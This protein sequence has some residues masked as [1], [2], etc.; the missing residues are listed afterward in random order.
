MGRH[1][2][3]D[4]LVLYYYGDAP[5]AHAVERHLQT[6]E[7][8]TATL[9]DIAATLDAIS[10]AD[11]PARD[12][13]YGLEV[14]QR[15]RHELPA[16]ESSG[17]TAW[18]SQRAALVAAAV[19]VVAAFAGGR[20]LRDGGAGRAQR[21]SIASNAPARLDR[22]DQPDLTARARF[23]AIGD[24][25][26]QSERV[27]MDL[28]NA[29]GR[30]VEI[31]DTQAWARR[32]IDDNRLY[33]ESA[34]QAGDEDIAL[35]LDDLERSLLDIVHEP[36]TLTRAD[37]DALDMRLDAAALLFKVRVLADELRER[38]QAPAP[39]GAQGSTI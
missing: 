11:A 26:E 22:P 28:V 39:A 6:C 27:L 12:E 32:L 14:W 24:H 29:D 33:R 23:A 36:S 19:I 18:L 34:V 35:V 10:R 15:I 8:C 7:A 21:D 25:L 31:G 38:E 30:P 13:R 3:D 17:W 5:R 9:R 4:D 37:L 2:S 20:F 1:Y 16:Q